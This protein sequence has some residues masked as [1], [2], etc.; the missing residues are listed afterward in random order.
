MKTV[1]VVAAIIT[2]RDSK[3]IFAT[4]RGYGN[5]KGWWEF[6]GGKI[7]EGEQ[8]RQALRREIKEE[9]DAQIIIEK[10]LKTIEWDYPTFHLKMHC[11]IVRLASESITL[12]EHSAAK[13]LSANDL[14]SIQWLPADLQLLPL[15]RAELE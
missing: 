1:E 6:P 4:Q 15:I 8:K 2:D 11:Y 12:K 7:E 9:L 3:K 14:E 13:W 5:Y 10:L